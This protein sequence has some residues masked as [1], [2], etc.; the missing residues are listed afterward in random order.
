MNPIKT[1]IILTKQLLNI[2]LQKIS[3]SKFYKLYLKMLIPNK[4]IFI[5]YVLK[6]KEIYLPFLELH[7]TKPELKLKLTFCESLTSIP[8]NLLIQMA[9]Y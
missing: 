3:L 6:C 4:V 5:Y 1:R 7:L 9:S 2:K 8:F